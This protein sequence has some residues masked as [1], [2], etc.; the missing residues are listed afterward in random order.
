MLLLLLLLLLLQGFPA[1]SIHGDKTQREREDA[2]K[3][4][5]T[6]KTPILVATDVAARGL[7]ISNVTQVQSCS[8]YYTIIDS[9]ECMFKAA[10]P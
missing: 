10:V 9:D 7:D 1:A 6:G 5:K 4:F 2:L 3:C 8:C